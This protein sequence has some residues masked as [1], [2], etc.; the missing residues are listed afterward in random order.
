MAEGTTGRGGVRTGA[1]VNRQ[2]ENPGKVHELVIDVEDCRLVYGVLS[3]G[4]FMG[5]EN[6]PFA[7]PLK[8]FEFHAA[9]RK[10]IPAL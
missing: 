4:D 5:M 1:V 10:L 6:K 7:M 3:I 9:E 8:T 2:D